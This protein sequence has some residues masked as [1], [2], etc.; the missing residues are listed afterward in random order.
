MTQRY[1]ASLLLHKDHEVFIVGLWAITG[2]EQ[3][4]MRIQKSSKGSSAYTMRRKLSLFLNSITSFSNKPLLFIS[5]LGVGIS[6]I[7]G[8]AASYLVFR[9]ILFNG[10]LLGWPSLIV[11][12]WF[13]GGLNI[14][15]L[16][17]I[18]IYISK[19]FMETKDRPI[20]VIREIFQSDE[21]QKPADE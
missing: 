13:L 15:C 4:P 21:N 12:V 19:I 10:Y 11:S 9:R 20:S 1:V 18:G 6:L 3:I 5:Y 2:F 8:I 16:G 14:F 7:A 17:I